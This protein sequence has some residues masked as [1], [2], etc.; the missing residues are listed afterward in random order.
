MNILI[1]SQY[2]WPENFRINEISK[3]LSKKGHKV[4]VYTTYPNYPF[5]D[6]YKN[7]HY[8]DQKFDKNIDIIRVPSVSRGSGGSINLFLNYF[9]FILSGIFFSH[10]RLSGKKYDYILTFATS[11]VTVTLISIYISFFKRS[12]LVMWLLDFWPDI[13]F[14]LR[15]VKSKFGKFFL[16]KIVNFIYKRQDCILVQS[17]T[18]FNKLVKLNIGLSKKKLIYFPSWPENI[19]INK[20]KK[21]E[22]IFKLNTKEIKIVFTGNIGEAQG[23]EKVLE[24]CKKIKKVKFKIFVVGTGRW[25][26]KIRDQI[27]RKHINNI[28][29]IG[30]KSVNKIYPFL[31]NAD[32]LLVTLKD[33]KVFDATIPGKFSTYLEFNKPILGLIGGETKSLIN[34]NNLGF[35][36]KNLKSKKENLKLLKFLKNVKKKQINNKK[37]ILNFFYKEKIL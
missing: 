20:N 15:Y 4:D 1:V 30:H 26:I 9:T 22:N 28:K 25:L 5:K 31:K 35:A 7:V 16:N 29:F 10:F 12:K 33:G 8:N 37:Y 11:P 3:Y 24:M 19:K 36:L 34:N 17:K 13:I 32:V 6:V 18:Y 14:E 23:F 2:F 21:I 27:N